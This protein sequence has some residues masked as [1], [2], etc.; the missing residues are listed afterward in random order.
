M[1]VT[2]SDL[3]DLLSVTERTSRHAR[4]PLQARADTIETC[5]LIAKMMM[6]VLEQHRSRPSTTSRASTAPPSMPT[7]PNGPSRSPPSQLLTFHIDGATE[8]KTS[9]PMTLGLDGFLRPSQP[10]LR[11]PPP[12]EEDWTD[13]DGVVSPENRARLTSDVEA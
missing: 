4:L 2:I 12:P 8:N 1:T 11:P 9:N 5:L 7:I 13:D 6:I 3:R 10:P